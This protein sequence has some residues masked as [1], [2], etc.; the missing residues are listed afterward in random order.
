MKVLN[1]DEKEILKQIS[2]ISFISIIIT[3]ISFS[4]AAF[5]GEFIG[6]L[7]LIFILFIIFLF[8]LIKSQW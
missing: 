7:S 5:Y 3:L 4:I 1:E 8:L 6:G 2:I